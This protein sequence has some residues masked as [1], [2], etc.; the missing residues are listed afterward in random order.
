MIDLAREK[1]QQLWREV[2][3]ADFTA[4]S[5]M[6][7]QEIVDAVES[8]INS[9]TTSY[10][11]VLPTQLLAKLADP[12]L[13]ARAVQTSSGLPGAYDA[14]S[15]CRYV[16]VPFNQEYHAVLG[17][18]SDP[19]VN[20]PLRIPAITREHLADKR[21]KAGFNSLVEVLNF[22]QEQPERVEDLYRLVLASI[23]RR[24]SRA[25]IVYPIPNRISLNGL[26]TGVASFLTARTGGRRLQAAALGLVRTIS[27]EFQ[28][29]QDVRS[30]EVNAADAQS[31]NVADIECCDA[32]GQVVFG[33]EVKD[34]PLRLDHVRDKLPFMREKR[35]R[36]L[37]FL[38]R[39]GRVP[40]NIE[41]LDDLQREQFI[42]GQN[43]YWC[44]FDRLL[45]TVATLIGENG[46]RRLLER[47]GGALDEYGVLADRESWRD[48]LSSI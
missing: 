12:R 16:V 36:E 37:L 46:R 33:V 41:E 14:R 43:L 8:S 10:R 5:P 30:A 34:C 9:P 25:H 40:E 35:V 48:T 45:A 39:G 15:L 23:G 1:L 27:Q 20:N 26:E 44:E 21:D 22:A 32:S 17:R 24:L 11:F 13:D 4:A 6:I 2:R 7:P 29:F 47:I 38:V 18:S 28:L 3:A 42:S 19:Y 31:G